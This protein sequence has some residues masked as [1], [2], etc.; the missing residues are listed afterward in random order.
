[1]ARKSTSC[2][3]PQSDWGAGTKS[4]RAASRSRVPA[5]TGRRQPSRASAKAPAAKAAHSRREGAAGLLQ[6]TAVT[7]P[8]VNL[9]VPLLAPRVP[10]LGAA[11]AQTRWA[12]QTVRANLP[13]RER[14]LYYG[15]LGLLA[16]VGVPGM[17]SCRRVGCGSVGGRTCR[18]AQ[19]RAGCLGVTSAGWSKNAKVSDQRPAIGP[20]FAWAHEGYA[21]IAVQREIG[22]E[23]PAG[24]AE[25]FEK[26]LEAIDGVAWAAYNGALGRVIVRFDRTRTSLAVLV[27]AVKTVER[28]SVR[29]T[30]NPDP[31]P[32]AAN[33]VALAA[34]IAS[35]GA[36]FVGRATRL[37]RLPAELAALTAATEHLPAVSKK[38]QARLG[39]VRTDLGVALTSSAIGAVSQVAMTSAADAAIRVL[40]LSETSA[41][42]GAL[43]RRV[44][45]L[46]PDAEASRAE[47]VSPAA[48]PA[49]LPD[50]PIE[51]YAQR[52]STVTLLAAGVLLPLAGIRR[53]ATALVVGSPRAA[54]I[55][56][57]AY[58]AQLG[59]VLARRGVVVR[60]PSA[61]RRLDRID[62]VIIDA[63][64]LMTGR[65]RRQPRRAGW[66][67]G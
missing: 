17:A 33:V 28:R 61:I 18:Y 11:T 30:R 22:G 24:L 19:W 14:M 39:S 65:D 49:A 32:T 7:V 4:A 46:C 2:D 60:D 5:E 43:A 15:G 29:I 54:E 44:A 40:R 59:R 8:V 38:L 37:P 57:E 47:T 55:G 31:D 6:R 52:I 1:M 26:P 12:A 45:D 21:H 42:R 27:E 3:D 56:R 34:D 50:G 66:R 67:L 20:R 41:Q 16:S 63:P 48:R 13:S 10:D 25:S 53:A 58:S 64:A 35:I 9:R 36:G 62:T 51:R 23:I